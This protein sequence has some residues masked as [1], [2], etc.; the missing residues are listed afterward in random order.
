MRA[1]A[2]LL[3]VATLMTSGCAWLFMDK[4]AEGYSRH[5]EPQC[6][7][8]VGWSV[9]D[10]VF[11][12]GNGVGII[13][14]IADESIPAQDKGPLIA[15]SAIGAVIHLASAAMASGWASKCR[16]AMARYERASVFTADRSRRALEARMARDE[17]KRSER[18]RRAAER[19]APPTPEPL[20]PVEVPPD[21][22]VTA[23]TQA[24]L[25]ALK[26]AESE[27]AE[28]EEPEAEYEDGVRVNATDRPVYCIRTGKAA[29]TCFD[30]Q[31]Q[32]AVRS[33]SC[34]RRTAFACFTY[35]VRTDGAEKMLCVATY[36]QCDVLS[37]GFAASR[38]YSDVTECAI[39]RVKK[40][41]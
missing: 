26:K 11:A 25:D 29:G 35:V 3:L 6:S 34:E 33:K 40:K 13:A 23:Q 28:E 15:I 9:L 31:A 7:E 30:K 16:N 19:V 1:L 37:D 36:G 32:C 38:E 27:P 14:A 10:G 39:F 21:A 18:E 20:E 2:A 24:V 12:V 4:P 8:S 41:R 17:A 22:G 5:E